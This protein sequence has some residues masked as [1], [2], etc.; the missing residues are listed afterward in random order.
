MRGS[1][2]INTDSRHEVHAEGQK[3]CMRT[4]CGIKTSVLLPGVSC[5]HAVLLPLLLHLQFFF[6]G[7]LVWPIFITEGH[8][9]YVKQQA[10]TTKG[11][12]L[13]ER[14]VHVPICSRQKAGRDAATT[15][16]VRVVP[17]QHVW[18]LRL[19]SAVRTGY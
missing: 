7:V 19:A 12:P 13:P 5:V 18:C 2:G 6:T 3:M 9:P 16:P 1:F 17:P 8:Q 15:G 14:R 10:P 11:A 4:G